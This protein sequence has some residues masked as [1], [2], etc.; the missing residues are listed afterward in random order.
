NTAYEFYKFDFLTEYGVTGQNRPNSIQLAEIELLSTGPVNFDSLI[1]LDIEAA[2]NTTPTSVYQRIEFDV[3]DPS[4]LATLLLEMQYDDGFVAYLNGTRVAS[5]AAP[6]LPK[7]NSTATSSRDD[8]DALVP[9]VFNLT[10]FLDS[11]VE[12]TNVL[13]I[14]VLNL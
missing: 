13:A 3:E 5:A 9:Q 2:W 10:A 14:H 11:L 7:F 12:G 8:A 4:T 1:D 6:T